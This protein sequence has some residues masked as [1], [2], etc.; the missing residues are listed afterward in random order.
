[1]RHIKDINEAINW[2]VQPGIVAMNYGISD[3]TTK[4]AVDI[5]LAYA[6]YTIQAQELKGG[7]E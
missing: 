5:V 3:E 4:E 1:M 7:L 2:L 6:L